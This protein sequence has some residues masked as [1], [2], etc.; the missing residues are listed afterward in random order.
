MLPS[1]SMALFKK[2]DDLSQLSSV[3]M[4]TVDAVGFTAD[5]VSC[6]EADCVC[7]QERLEWPLGLCYNAADVINA[8][9]HLSATCG[10][11]TDF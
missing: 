11:P 10:L 2:K 5:V 1:S 9:K 3:R 4:T 6:D 7:V 8:L